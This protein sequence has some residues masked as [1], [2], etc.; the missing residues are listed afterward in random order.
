MKY[1][2]IMMATAVLFASESKCKRRQVGSVLAKDGRIRT[3]GYNGTIKNSKVNACERE[4]I[5]CPKCKKELNKER[6]KPDGSGVSAQCLDCTTISKF[7]SMDELNSFVILKTNDNVVHAEENVIADAAKQGIPTAGTTIYVT[8]SPCMRC[9]KLIASAGISRVIFKDRYSD[10][11]SIGFL[12]IHGIEVYQY[13]GV[14]ECLRL[15]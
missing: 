7:T 9:A 3:T 15:Q 14:K 10:D 11:S 5:F 12:N 6:F 1:N 2:R 13:D 8:T 4:I